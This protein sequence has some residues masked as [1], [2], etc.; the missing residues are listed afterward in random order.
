V[1][2]K[3]ERDE[4]TGDYEDVAAGSRGVRIA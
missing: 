4:H 1:K 2:Q 3:P